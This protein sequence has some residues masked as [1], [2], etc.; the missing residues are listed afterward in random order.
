[1]A[2]AFDP[3]ADDDDDDDPSH[4][5]VSPIRSAA[6]SG[7]SARS[8]PRPRGSPQNNNHGAAQ[9]HQH[10]NVHQTSYSS[11]SGNNASHDIMQEF[12]SFPS[13]SL[14]DDNAEF[15][16]FPSNVFPDADDTPRAPPPT[17]TTTTE[18]NTNTD[19][20]NINGA[21]PS[22]FVLSEEMSVIH[23]SDSSLCSVKIRGKVSVEQQQEQQQA[24]INK[25]DIASCHLL[26]DDPQ[27]H[28]ETVTSKNLDYAQPV[29][30]TDNIFR[31]STP[32]IC[33]GNSNNNNHADGTEWIETPLIEYT[34]GEKLRPVPIVSSLEMMVECNRI[35]LLHLLTPVSTSTIL[36]YINTFFT[37]TPP[38]QL[39]T[40]NIQEFKDHTQIMFQLRV[41]PRNETSLINAVVLVSVP[42]Q[43][44]GE[45]SVVNSVGRSIGK[46]NIDTNWSSDVTRILS[47]KLGELYSGAIV[48]FEASFPIDTNDGSS[49]EP[50]LFAQQQQQEEGG[51]T[52]FPVLMRY[53][54]EGSLLSCID[55]DFGGGGG[56]EE[57]GGSNKMASSS[58]KRRYKV[59]H[60]EV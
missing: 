54:S 47:W 6:Q 59:Y 43:Y 22:S 14:N 28:L 23:K 60:R 29:N 42:E 30:N 21:A 46:G 34:C 18:T 55:L 15:D 2:E 36:I 1:M 25:Q 58:V 38:P 13:M 9:H 4:H 10:H 40:T 37:H 35:S 8:S 41:N 56:G 48:E 26:L 17:T 27:G 20:M 49:V 33:H 12:A 45:R 7:T 5:Q 57:G 52:K 44:N 31:I 19:P 39:I 51:E 3:F 53:K 24:N 50:L 11:S 16:Y 32:D